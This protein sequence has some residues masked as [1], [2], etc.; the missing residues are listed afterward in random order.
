LAKEELIQLETDLDILYSDFPGGFEKED[1]KV[2]VLEK[3]KRKLFLLKQGGGNL[4]T[5]E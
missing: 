3:E 4:A 5:K 1:E 2:L